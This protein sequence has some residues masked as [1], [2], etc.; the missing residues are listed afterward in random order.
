[1]LLSAPGSWL[2][3]FMCKSGYRLK[4]L[5]LGRISFH[6]FRLVDT[7]PVLAFKHLM[8]SFKPRFADASAEL[9]GAW[10]N[11]HLQTG[12]FN[13]PRALTKLPVVIHTQNTG[14]GKPR[15]EVPPRDTWALWHFLKWQRVLNVIKEFSLKIPLKKKIENIVVKFRTTG[16]L[17][18][19]NGKR[20]FI[21][22]GGWKFS[23]LLQ[24]R[25]F[26]F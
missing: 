23:D 7:L 16:F 4:A 9:P 13:E 8:W 19:T 11:G 22:C 20:D 10:P 1:M 15:L 12:A 14:Q 5:W 26:N 2:G 6:S 18:T 24:C 25:H 3:V 21:N 17:G